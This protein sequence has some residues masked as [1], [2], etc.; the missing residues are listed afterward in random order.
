MEQRF[1]GTAMIVAVIKAVGERPVPRKT[2]SGQVSL[3]K[4]GAPRKGLG[5]R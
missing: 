5:I 2:L 3:E 1:H 4:D